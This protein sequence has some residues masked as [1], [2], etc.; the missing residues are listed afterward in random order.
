MSL[1]SAVI[2]AFC[3]GSIFGAVVVS[4]VAIGVVRETQQ[5]AEVYFQRYLEMVRSYRELHRDY[6]GNVAASDEWRGE[7]EGGRR[8]S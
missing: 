8:W 7:K 3:V 1:T 4:I 6:E 2:L 5:T